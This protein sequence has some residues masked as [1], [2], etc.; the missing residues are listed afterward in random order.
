MT[1]LLS[2][3]RKQTIGFATLALVLAAGTGIAVAAP[4]AGNRPN[5]G[6]S[7]DQQGC[8]GPG[9]RGNGQQRAER[10]KEL[11]TNKDGKVSDEERKVGI[12][13]RIDARFATQDKNKDGLL[14]ADELPKPQFDRMSKAD[15]NKDGKLSKQEIEAAHANGTLGPRGHE[16]AGKG[17][18]GR[19]PMSEADRKAHMQQRFTEDD[20]N[21]DGFLTQTEVPQRW[22]RI[23]VADSN[24]D[25]KISLAELQAAHDTGKIGPR[26]KRG[27]GRGQKP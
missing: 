8:R 16:H 23:S 10:L 13:K 14:T 18:E 25:K 9:H 3:T 5:S 7:T 1:K 19:G 27:E 21:K 2:L 20:K 26:G 24:N 22:E 11:D 12:Q 15:A 6:A 4:N 17:P